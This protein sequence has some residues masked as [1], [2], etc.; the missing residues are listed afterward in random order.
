VA[1]ARRYLGR[2]YQ[3]G[4]I[5]VRGDSRG[6]VLR[7]PTANLKTPAEKLIPADGVYVCYA[8]QRRW[9][10][11]IASIG[12]RPTF[13]KGGERRVEVHLLGPPARAELLGRRLRVALLERLRG[14]R[15]FASP[16]ALAAQMMADRTAAW[17]RLSALQPPGDVL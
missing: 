1:P 3:L 8:G 12:V 5:V 4:G 16:D 13:E 11:A 17:E 15:A 6:R 14:E 7:F 9:R 10:P 2:A